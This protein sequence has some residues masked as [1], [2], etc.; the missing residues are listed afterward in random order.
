MVDPRNCYATDSEDENEDMIN[1]P[2]NYNSSEAKCGVCGRQIEY[3]DVARHMNF[4]I[5]NAIKCIWRH[6]KNGGIQ[7]IEKAIWYLK[8]YIK[9][10]RSE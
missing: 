3:I 9:N 2:H 1:Q 8:D 6:E 10:N 5:G 7:D 4:N